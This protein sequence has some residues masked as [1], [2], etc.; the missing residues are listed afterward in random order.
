M[1]QQK[2]SIQQN[3]LENETGIKFLGWVVFI[4]LRKN[5]NLWQKIAFF[6]KPQQ[7]YL[8]TSVHFSY[9]FKCKLS[10]KG[11]PQ[12]HRRRCRPIIIVIIYKAFLRVF[13][14]AKKHLYL[15]DGVHIE[16]E[17]YYAIFCDSSWYLGRIIEIVD[18]NKSRI[19]F[20]KKKFWKYKWPKHEDQQTVENKYVF[21][22]P[23]DLLRNE[24]FTM[25]LEIMG[26]IN[27]L[28]KYMR[29]NK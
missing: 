10:Q 26:K 27:N 3:C 19:K 12:C 18:V 9:I 15:S 24:R 29:K 4:L 22:G 1:A 6:S 11:N 23:V 7:K 25:R 2:S 21:F 28:F 17:K 5:S 20:L 13:Q 14:T 16:A 8:L